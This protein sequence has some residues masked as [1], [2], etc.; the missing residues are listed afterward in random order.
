MIAALEVIRIPPFWKLFRYFKK[1]FLKIKAKIQGKVFICNALIG[2]SPYNTSINSDMTV[3][4]NCQDVA[5]EGIIGDLY[6]N[7]F[8]EIFIIS[9]NG[10]LIN[11]PQKQEAALLADHIYFSIDDVNNWILSHYQR[12]G[13][14]DKAFFNMKELI[15]LLNE[16]GQ[17]KPV[18]EWDVR[19]IKFEN[20]F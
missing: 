18:I 13:S 2:N 16:R 3:S 10:D 8:K 15:R 11:T 4:C 7:D 19:E 17:K 14:F 1:H 6:K 12:G 20:T 5:G 9:T